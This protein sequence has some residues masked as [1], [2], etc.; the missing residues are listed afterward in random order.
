MPRDDYM[1]PGVP[2]VFCTLC[3]HFLAALFISS[4]WVLDSA[5]YWIG[6]GRPRIADEQM[7][8]PRFFIL[9][10]ILSIEKL[11]SFAPGACETQEEPS[12]NAN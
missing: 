4:A 12:P 10:A 2:R 9:Y 6:C 7:K 1:H 8:A 3:A 11:Q 5:C